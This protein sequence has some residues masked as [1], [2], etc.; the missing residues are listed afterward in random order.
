MRILSHVFVVLTSLLLL[1]GC[2]LGSNEAPTKPKKRP[3]SEHLVE[4]QEAVRAPVSSAYQ[5]TGSLKARRV[6]RIYSQEEGRILE[7]PWFEGDQVEK[8]ALLLRLDDALLKAEVDK[9]RATSRQARV[10]LKRIGDLVKRNAASK[11][12][13]ERTRTR[14][15]VAKAEQR[16]LETRLGYMRIKAPFSGLVSERLVEPGDVVEEHTHVL[17]LLDPA[18]LIIEVQVSELLLPHLKLGDPVSI[19]IDALGADSFPGKILRIHPSLDRNT[20]QGTIETLL[21]PVPAGALAGQFARVTLNTASAP[22]L[23][24]P[25]PALQRDRKSEYVYLVDGESKARRR[26][27]R[28]GLR[29]AD[30]VE[31]LE[32]LEAGEQ[33]VMRGFLGLT[34]GKTVAP[35]R[36]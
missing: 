5:R 26:D 3:K 13:L 12:E 24:I 11:D 22:R 23:M 2:N 10:D 6:A 9:A 25:F 30:R 14:L 36:R 31:I 20:R 18:S 28:S 8:N 15:D 7:L 35:T 4:I 17:T 29:V 34:D 21:E 32:G 19:R 16:M 33:V 1:G 27:V